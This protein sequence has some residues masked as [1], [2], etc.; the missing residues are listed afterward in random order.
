M[1]SVTCMAP[2]LAGRHRRRYSCRHRMTPNPPHPAATGNN[3]QDGFRVGSWQ[4]RP[5]QGVIEQ[6]S[7]LVHVE[8]K[9]MDVLLCLARHPGQVVSRETLLDEV[10]AGVV[11]TDEVVT[12]CISE[13]RTVLRDTG[14]DRQFI[15]TIPKRGYS[16]LVPVEPL[17]SGSVMA[18]APDPALPVTE[19]A[20]DAAD[21]G[22]P[23][24]LAMLSA[25]ARGTMMAGRQA[26]ATGRSLLRSTLLGI[27]VFVV[28]IVGLGV[29]LA[30]LSSYDGV[31][32]KVMP[33]D[34]TGQSI[35]TPAPRPAPTPGSFHSL[36]VLPL[37][38]LGG[39]G[40]DTG[41]FSEGLTEDIRNALI[42]GTALQIAARTRTA[43]LQDES[44]DGRE[45]APAARHHPA[46]RRAHRLSGLGVELRTT[47]GGKGDPAIRGPEGHRPP[48]PIHGHRPQGAVPEARLKALRA[49]GCGHRRPVRHRPCRRQSR[50]RL[51]ARSATRPARGAFPR[52]SA[53]C[54]A[55]HHWPL[56]RNSRTPPRAIS[57]EYRS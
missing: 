49:S 12:R 25:T 42:N 36:A 30:L 6:A 9:V 15:R 31:D 52:A 57:P 28:S 37:V 22:P 53:S 24:A 21:S 4:V 8:P 1:D 16:L 54:P 2:P 13:L 11:V 7:H 43:D 45:I 14:R 5:L 18:D 41:Y 46:H 10:W 56:S 29:L 34:N 17:E 47:D 44:M 55:G 3:L 39:S 20:P 32:V 23:P 40:E 19:V 35:S 26:L 51:P 50:R 48:V 33:N 38:N 27:G